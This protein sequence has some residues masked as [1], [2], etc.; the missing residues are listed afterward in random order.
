MAVKNRLKVILAQKNISQ[1]K[2][3]ED[4]KIN[5]STLSNIIN[6]KQNCT[7][8]LALNLAEYLNVKI[9]DIF[10]KENKREFNQGF[11]R[12]LFDILI[13]KIDKTYKLYRENIISQDQLISLYKEFE[14]NFKEKN[15]VLS[16]VAMFELYIA[17]EN[18]EINEIAKEIFMYGV[19]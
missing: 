7:M 6:E 2:L 11:D 9:E 4:L 5:K 18:I 3:V 13:D 8:E 12:D 15:G 17:E 10:Y 1:N 16:I 14:R 19:L